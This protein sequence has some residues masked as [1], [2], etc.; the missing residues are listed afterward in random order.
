MST[1]RASNLK[2]EP[3]LTTLV[4]HSLERYFDDLNGQPAAELYELVVRQVEQPLLEIVM[5]ET[6]GNISKAAQVLGIN[7]ATPRGVETSRD[8]Q[9]S[10]PSAA[11]LL[12]PHP[13]VSQERGS[14][15]RRGEVSPLF[16]SSRGVNHLE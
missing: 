3:P 10:E 15:G 11:D 4:K 14:G 13:P 5:R 1:S 16:S 9:R 2:A 8:S 7:R 12:Q 6:G